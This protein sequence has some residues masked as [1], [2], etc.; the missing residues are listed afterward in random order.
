MKLSGF[1]KKEP[2]S[3]SNTLSHKLK[4]NNQNVIEVLMVG[5][6]EPRKGYREVLEILL[7]NVDVFNFKITIV[8]RLGWKVNAERKMIKKHLSCWI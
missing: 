3:S 7:K 4:Q 5:T 8:G 2:S 1:S 6:L